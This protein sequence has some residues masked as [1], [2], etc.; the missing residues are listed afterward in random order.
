MVY[1]IEILDSSGVVRRLSRLR[2]NCIRRGSPIVRQTARPYP[3][4]KD[5][6]N[7]RVNM[8]KTFYKCIFTV[9]ILSFAL[10]LY[11]EDELTWPNQ[12]FRL[13]TVLSSMSNGMKA[14]DNAKDSVHPEFIKPFIYLTETEECLPLNLASPSQIGN[15]S[16]CNC[17]VIVLSFRTECKEKARAPHISY[18]FDPKSTWVSGRNVLFFAALDRKPGY[19]YYIILND[20]TL[21]RFNVFT[22]P[23]MAASLEPFR[24]VENWLLDYEPALGVLDYIKHGAKVH[25]EK[26]RALCGINQ[27]SLVVPVVVYDAIFNAFHYKAIL[28]L[29][30]YHEEHE[31][32]SW[33]HT[34]KNVIS[35]AELKFRG[36]VFMFTPVEALNPRH[37]AYPKYNRDKFLIWKEFI[38]E[39]QQQAPSKYRNHS[40]FKEFLSDPGRYAR[41]SK[42]ICQNATKHQAI[43]PYAHLLEN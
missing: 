21:V 43:V 41:E 4:E 36:Q 37:R 13:K 35:Q 15:A 11:F 1:L 12:K 18:L 9:S 16:T 19:H 23:A 26:R 33:Y 32:K 22:P 2:N 6:S 25:F 42:T 7:S 20:D 27:T 10:L 24:A 31:Y 29:L 3:Q 34:H 40:L 5:R 28:H 38:K 17:D 39:I 30:P 8:K 14:V